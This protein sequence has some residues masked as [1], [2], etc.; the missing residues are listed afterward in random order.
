MIG[1]T[2][3]LL[4]ASQH[5][6]GLMIRVIELVM[7]LRPNYTII[8]TTCLMFLLSCSNVEVVETFNDNGE[9]S[10]SYEVDPKTKKRHG[11]YRRYIGNKVTEEAFYHQDTLVGTRVIYDDQGNRLIEETYV[12]GTYHGPYLSYYPDGT[13]K[14][15][16][17]YA[18]GTMEGVWIKY[19]NSGT[20]MEK[21][22]M[23]LNAENG[24]FS[25][26][27]ENGKIKA[28]GSYLDGDNEHGE[29]LLYDE[30]G[31]LERKMQCDQGICHTT[32]SRTKKAE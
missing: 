3:S 22:S 30:K 11:T 16:G 27:Y 4:S 31:Q 18:D 15:E 8:A 14:L 12:G 20:I 29:L 28:E 2:F 26:Y 19:Y 7:I 25:E 21:V 5:I 9:L 1:C 17:Q 24:P 6:G 23:H 13:V 32:W 10:E